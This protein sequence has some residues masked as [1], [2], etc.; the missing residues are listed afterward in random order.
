[1]ALYTYLIEKIIPHIIE[2]VR[3]IVKKKTIS[4]YYVVRDYNNT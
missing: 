4:L 3:I 2:K 1:L